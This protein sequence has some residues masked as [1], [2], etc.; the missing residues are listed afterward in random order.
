MI[1]SNPEN[2]SGPENPKLEIRLRELAERSFLAMKRHSDFINGFVDTPE[3]PIVF[4]SAKVFVNTDNVESD[5][6]WVAALKG[7]GLT[8]EQILKVWELKDAW[9]SMARE[10]HLKKFV[11]KP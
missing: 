5:R 3:L 11:D 6:H 8:D 1:S 7:S 2:E 10:D 9:S 4:D